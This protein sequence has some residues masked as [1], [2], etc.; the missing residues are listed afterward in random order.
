[1]NPTDLTSK[2]YQALIE[3]GMDVNSIQQQIT[4]EIAR[5]NDIKPIHFKNPEKLNGTLFSSDKRETYKV[6][7][8]GRDLSIKE[9][10]WTWHVESVG[11]TFE[12]KLTILKYPEKNGYATVIRNSYGVSNRFEIDRNKLNDLTWMI[13]QIQTIGELPF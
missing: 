11:K 7:F 10:N 12:H 6:T 2:L 4:K 5:L 8:I 1:M 9:D 13:E 3:A